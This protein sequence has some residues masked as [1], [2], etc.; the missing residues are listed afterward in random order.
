[1]VDEL[2]SYTL[3]SPVDVP[4]YLGLRLDEYDARGDNIILGNKSWPR[5]LDE[6]ASRK[7]LAPW[8][9]Q[10]LVNTLVPGVSP[11]A[12]GRFQAPN[13]A[14]SVRMPNN[15]VAFAGLLIYLHTIGYPG[16]WLGEFV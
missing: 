16:H 13:M 3:L 8:L 15:L 9:H 5:P 2:L 7:E 12:M 11:Q 4:R 1:L 14:M 10:L 6:L